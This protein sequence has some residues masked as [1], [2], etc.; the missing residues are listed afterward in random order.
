[1]KKVKV[2][3]DIIMALLIIILMDITITGMLWHEILGLSVF[4][5][6]AIHIILNLKWIKAIGTHLLN[7]QLNKRTKFV[8]ILDLLIFLLVI[9]ILITGIL[10]SNN[11]F[12]W[13][14]IPNRGI[15][16]KMHRF[17]SWWGF[18]LLSIHIG[19]HWG[20]M[21][22]SLKNKSKILK[23]NK[24]IKIITAILYIAI[25]VY[26]IFTLS[27]AHI[28]NSF[29]PEF[30]TQ[31]RYREW[32]QNFKNSGYRNNKNMRRRYQGGHTLRKQGG[33][34]IIG[35]ICV[36]VLFVGGTYYTIEWTNKRKKK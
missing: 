35:N 2:T 1:M 17:F 13:F 15:Y 16:K 22:Q 34:N 36:M 19:I 5:V 29:I 24:N 3:I 7:K 11:I 27:D 26:G 20:M 14:H 4:G 33:Y 28:Y 10:I 8:F 12:H 23:G 18:V 21:V 32:N 25:A 9:G 30:H 6:F 31:Q